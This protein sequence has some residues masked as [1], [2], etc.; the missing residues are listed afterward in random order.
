M[1]PPSPVRV[2]YQSLGSLGG[3]HTRAINAITT[4]G[5]PHIPMLTSMQMDTTHVASVKQK[6]LKRNSNMQGL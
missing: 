2:L 1:P 3:L 4:N 5:I 6:L